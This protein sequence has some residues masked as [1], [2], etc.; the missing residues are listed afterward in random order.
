MHID[1]RSDSG[2]V[3]VLGEMV[4]RNITQGQA[5]NPLAIQADLIDGETCEAIS[6]SIYLTRNALVATGRDL[7]HDIVEKGTQFRHIIL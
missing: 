2:A 7:A 5:G 1:A 4:I 3:Y 6:V